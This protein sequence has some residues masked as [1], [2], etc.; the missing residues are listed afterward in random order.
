MMRELELTDREYRA[1]V[2]ALEAAEE[3]AIFSEA[4]ATFRN[5]R[6]EMVSQWEEGE[7]R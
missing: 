7:S 3:Q 4:E 2:D 6:H 1:I 5:A